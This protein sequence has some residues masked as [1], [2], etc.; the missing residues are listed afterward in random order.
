VGFV[1]LSFLFLVIAEKLIQC[2]TY[3]IEFSEFPVVVRWWFFA[4]MLTRKLDLLRRWSDGFFL[5]AQKG[6]Q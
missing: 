6:I 4:V 2:I 3:S 1:K 5:A